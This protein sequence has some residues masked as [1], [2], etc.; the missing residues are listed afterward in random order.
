VEILNEYRLKI[1][2]ELLHDSDWTVSSIAT[3]IGYRSPHH[4]QL[5]FR[6]H[7][8]MTPKTYRQQ[9]QKIETIS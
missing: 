1:A 8:G 4:F 9:S 6:Q 5:L 2:K 7:T 3:F